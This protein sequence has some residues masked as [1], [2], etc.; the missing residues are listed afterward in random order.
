MEVTWLGHAAFLL[1]G[2][3]RVLVDPFLTGNP[4][5]AISAEEVDCDLVCVTH[6][7][8]EGPYLVFPELLVLDEVHFVGHDE[9]GN[10]TRDLRGGLPPALQSGE[11]QG[12]G[13]VA[14]GQ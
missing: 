9:R 10:L 6:A 1:E 4:A 8:A 7:S 13:H 12:A 2:D 3:D 14:D 11:G 5:A